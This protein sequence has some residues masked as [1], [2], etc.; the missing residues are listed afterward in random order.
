VSYNNL[1]ANLAAQARYPTAQPLL[2]KALGI[3]RCLLTDDRPKEATI[4]TLAAT[5]FRISRKDQDDVIDA[6]RW[7]STTRLAAGSMRTDD[8]CKRALA[9]C[10]A[11]EVT[12]CQSMRTFRVRPITFGADNR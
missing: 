9:P 6:G 3:N 4:N 12:R 10:A 1:A 2:E 5:V 11:F 8:G 7:A